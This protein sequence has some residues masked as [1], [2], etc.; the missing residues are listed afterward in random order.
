MSRPGQAAPAAGPAIGAIVDALAARL[1][2]IYAQAEQDL[3]EASA[4]VVQR[5][6]TDTGA[7][8]QLHMLGEL[9]RAAEQVGTQL[10]TR[11]GPIAAGILHEAARHG[12]A[13]AAAAVRDAVAGH[14]R[15]AQTYLER[16]H[17]ITGHAVAAANA[18]AADLAGR[19]DAARHAILRFPDDAYRAAVAEATTRQ[20]LGREQ[21]TPQATQHLAWRELTRQ[22][23]TG[24]TDT[25]G[26]KWNLSSYVEMASRTAV[27]RAYNQAHQDRMTA[28]GV[29]YFTVNHD[30]HPCPLCRPFEGRVLVAA[31]VTGLVHD[32]DAATGDAVSFRV[33]ATLDQAR[34]A[35][36]QHPNCR[37]VLIA[38]FP[39]V[40]KTTAEPAWTAAD[41]VRYDATQRL[42]QLERRVRATKREAAAAI[43]PAGKADAGRKVRQLQAEIRAHVARHDLVRRPRREQLDLGNK[44]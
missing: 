11:T 33:T 24:Y 28:T 7:L 22:G 30:G 6:F 26:R 4:R 27:Q 32:R 10:R 42:R 36:F 14:A 1:V 5:G 38:Y 43:D 21:L 25:S 37:H 3:L 44:P 39:G 19:L 29:R 9:R 31:G 13:A 17:G 12:E 20:V 41:Q 18:V 34:L 16:T 40:T 23:I 15:L 2:A 35:G 8:A